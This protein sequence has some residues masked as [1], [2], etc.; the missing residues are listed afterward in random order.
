MRSY[1]LVMRS[2]RLTIVTHRS[3]HEYHSFFIFFSYFFFI[4][5][6]RLTPR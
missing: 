2:P 3:L 6:T 4:T 1:Q 5:S